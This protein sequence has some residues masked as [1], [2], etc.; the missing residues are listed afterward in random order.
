[1]HPRLLNRAVR[2]TTLALFL[3]LF[4]F[5]PAVRAAEASRA[6]AIVPETQDGQLPLFVRT[7]PGGAAALAARVE[8]LGGRVTHRFENLDAI[9]ITVPRAVAEEFAANPAV[10][11]A[12]RQ[13]WV[14]RTIAPV[15][16]PRMLA[17]HSARRMDP[18]EEFAALDSELGN[19]RAHTAP[20]SPRGSD[21]ES[22][23]G[24]DLI[25]GAAQAWKVAGH[26]DGIV[27][28]II[29]TGV[30]PDHPMIMGNVIG[31]QNLVPAEEEQ[32]ID[33]D[34]DHVPDGLSFDWN[35]IENNGHGT[36]CAGLVAGHADLEFPLDHPLVASL[37]VHSPESVEIGDKSAIVRLRGV[38][39]GAS[40]YAIKI[41]PY[42]GGFSPDARV[43]EAIDRLVT[44]KRSGE[45]DVDVISMSLS[46]PVLFDGLNSLDA[47]VDVASSFG[48]TCV[49]AASNEGPS[50][51]SV[52]SPGSA[53]SSLTVGAAQD[54][55]HTRVA[56]EVAFGIPAGMGG[57]LYSWD[58]PKMI[59]FSSRGL[60][61]DRR[62]KPDIL[63][64]GFLVFSSGLR[65]SD[66]NGVNDTPSFGFG[67]GTSFSTPTVAG[68]AA[69]VTAYGDQLGG[70]GR[71]PFV[72][73]VLK[74][75][76]APIAEKTSVSEREQGRGYVH[77]PG[78]LD[79]LQNGGY[80]S[81]G[82]AD[83]TH[84]LLTRMSVM[85]GAVSGTTP[86]LQPGETYNV[87]LTVPGT[88]S[89]IEFEFPTVTLGTEQNPIV[90]DAMGAQIHTAKRGGSGDYVFAADPFDG[91]LTAGT[92]YLME[93]PE[94][95]TVRLTFSCSAFNYSPASASWSAQ[96]TT[97]VPAPEEIIEEVLHHG[98]IAEHVVIVPE[99][100]GALGIRL[101]WDHDW[102]QF[103]TVDLD[104]MVMTPEGMFPIATIDSPEYAL[105]ENPPD[106]EWTIWITDLDTALGPEHYRLETYYVWP[107]LQFTERSDVPPTPRILG[108]SPNPA[109][110]ATEIR[111]TLP[112]A[113]SAS[114]RVFDVA[115]RTV[116]TLADGPYESGEHAILWDGANGA[117]E[118]V[119][120]GVYFVRVEAK[121]G[122]SVRKL[123]RLD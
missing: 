13:R 72:A 69:L 29:D 9:S 25:T 120:A 12:E 112:A 78:A 62:V 58:V 119:G 26:G 42:D 101:V 107:K 82:E 100:L 113:S 64:T 77:I 81:A 18:G 106:G 44:M 63:A 6:S 35:A 83:P 84:Q 16:L 2:L 109:R 61:A 74:K 79:L 110:G 71:A 5:V 21:P 102:T 55:L 104:M 56:G 80:I 38:A 103:P 31:G 7:A 118:A 108:T 22:F 75:A 121:S 92:T 51:I 57:L 50:L 17:P 33:A 24:Y 4:A 111:F 20:L 114:V 65:D 93:T 91:G 30:Y 86:E 48:I 96:A 73:N 54:P 37:E 90:G 67:S 34:G 23:F 85:N 32:A 28:A 105:I 115:G 95:G 11:S 43:A 97:E 53:F 59:E 47:M 27:V 68:A 8:A 66:Q 76:A 116:R 122:V 70:L 94:P 14:H 36:F 123:T 45:L 89:G 46:G 19:F 1:M 117:G 60:T 40:L 52:G 98:E 10:I 49:S 15:E 39:P 87:L 99:H 41:F 88:A 3:A